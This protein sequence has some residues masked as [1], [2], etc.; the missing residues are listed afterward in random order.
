VHIRSLLGQIS[1]GVI[2][3]DI[4]ATQLTSALDGPLLLYLSTDQVGLHLS[5][6]LS[7]GWD[8]LIRRICR[9]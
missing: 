5:E 8:D 7:T 4:L 6:R 9:P 3:L 2:D 1:L